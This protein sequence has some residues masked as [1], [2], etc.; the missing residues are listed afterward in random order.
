[1][2]NMNAHIL[3]DIDLVEK[4]QIMLNKKGLDLTTELNEF[5]K[6]IVIEE[7]KEQKE[8]TIENKGDLRAT[9]MGK[10]KGQIWMSD[11]FDDPLPEM[12]DYME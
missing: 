2:E 9:L 3:P 1:M 6:K 10:Y 8:T 11:D 12:K 4:A 7:I 5:L